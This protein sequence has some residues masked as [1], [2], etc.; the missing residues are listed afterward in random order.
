MLDAVVRIRPLCFERSNV[1]RRSLFFHL[2]FFASERASVLFLGHLFAMLY[3]NLQQ[4][5]KTFILF[6]KKLTSTHAKHIYHIKW[7]PYHQPISHSKSLNLQPSFQ[8]GLRGAMKRV[9]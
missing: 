6:L 3:S 4:E 7:C 5:K 1:G 2:H 9:V 8:N